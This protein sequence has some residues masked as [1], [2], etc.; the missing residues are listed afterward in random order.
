MLV[1]AIARPEKPVTVITMPLSDSITCV[2]S[3]RT[4]S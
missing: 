4:P 2:R 1:C 3:T